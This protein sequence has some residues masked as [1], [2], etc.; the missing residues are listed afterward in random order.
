M[1][2]CDC[3]Q[4]NTWIMDSWSQL[5]GCKIWAWIYLQ[6]DHTCMNACIC[7]YIYIQI[8]T[9]YS[10]TYMCIYHD[11]CECVCVYIYIYNLHHTVYV[12]INIQNVCAHVCA[13]R[14]QIN[15]DKCMYLCI[16]VCLC[17]VQKQRQGERHRQ[18]QRAPKLT[19]AERKVHFKH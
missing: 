5:N 19:R 13:R 6:L 1:H 7:T 10:Y 16:F 3:I 8:Q 2:H 12:Y 18:R 15:A 9:V 14:T 4:M 11:L 17:T